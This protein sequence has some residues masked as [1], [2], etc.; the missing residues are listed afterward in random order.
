MPLSVL[1]VGGETL[2]R[3]PLGAVLLDQALARAGVA[4]QV[5]S[6]GLRAIPGHPVD[7]FTDLVAQKHGVDLRNHRARLLTQPM[8]Q[9]ADLV[10]T[11]DPALRQEVQDF[12]PHLSDRIRLFDEG[13]GIHDPRHRSIEFHQA[14]HLTMAEAARVLAAR[15]SECRYLST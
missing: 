7:T 14:A 15:L 3:S 12:A 2:C 1:V 10:L 8:L 5:A 9:T 4:A 6:A 11:M 13:S